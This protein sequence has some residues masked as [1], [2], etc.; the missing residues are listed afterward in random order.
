MPSQIS[1]SRRYSLP[2]LH[3]L[4]GKGF[5][6]KKNLQV[7]GPCSR[8][9]GHDYQIEV[10]ITGP[11]DAMTGLMICRDELDSMV[12]NRLIEPYSGKN[13]SDHFLH[14]TGEALALEFH[15]I[16][17]PWIKDP[18]RLLSV[19]VRET[20]KNSFHVGEEPG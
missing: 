20:R 5:S 1:L 19:T 17:E 16:L 4:T 12:R 18:L 3:T 9:H 15:G 11:I 13:L 6:K 7:F 10:T 2:A 14:T 8:L